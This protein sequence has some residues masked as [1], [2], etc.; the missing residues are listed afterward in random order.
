MLP[1]EAIYGVLY[2]A[3]NDLCPESKALPIMQ[4]PEAVRVN[5]PELRWKPWYQLSGSRLDVQIGP[6]VIGVNCDC[7]T[8]YMGW[9]K[10]S[11]YVSQIL[12]CMDST[13]LVKVISRIGVRYISFF[14]KVNIFEQLKLTIHREGTPI[15]GEK[16]TF[17]TLIKEE[18]FTQLLSLNNTVMLTSPN[19][20][21]GKRGSTFDIDTFIMT[22]LPSFEG[23][24]QIIKDG[25]SLEKRLFFSLLKD[26]F[27]QSLNPTYEQGEAQ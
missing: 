8:G 6:E 7:S 10:F 25:H 18:K 5:A 16:T 27:L 17:T 20:P 14:E 24:N 11:N 1:K 12:D 4:L 19:L 2:N 21:Q 9:E 15:Y 23:V 3:L 26:N 22:E 13:K